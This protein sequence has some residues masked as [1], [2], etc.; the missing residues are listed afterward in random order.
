MPIDR[1]IK[2]QSTNGSSTVM[3]VSG[4][5][6]TCTDRYTGQA[7]GAEGRHPFGDDQQSS[8]VGAIRPRNVFPDGWTRQEVGQ[9]RTDVQIQNRQ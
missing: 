6:V 1:Q 2:G 4:D 9:S 7:R 5:G 8:R 3:P